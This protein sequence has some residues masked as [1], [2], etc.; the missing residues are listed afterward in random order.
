[1]IYLLYSSCNALTDF[2]LRLRWFS[3]FS[4]SI[5]FHSIQYVLTQ[6]TDAYRLFPSFDVQSSENF[7]TIPSPN[8][9]SS[10]SLKVK[11][12]YLL[13]LPDVFFS[14]TVLLSVVLW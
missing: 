11:W 5:P 8:A 9:I 2:P 14:M 1:M 12:L 4:G 3:F 13:M 7:P 6:S 10:L